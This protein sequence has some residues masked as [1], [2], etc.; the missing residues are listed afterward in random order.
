MEKIFLLSLLISHLSYASTITCPT[1]TE[2]KQHN[3]HGWVPLI[4]TSNNEPDENNVEEFL[5][6]LDSFYLAEWRPDDSYSANCYYHS[7]NELYEELYLGNHAGGINQ[8]GHW[9][10]HHS[11]EIA[12]CESES[13][14]TCRFNIKE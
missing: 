8:N 9:R 10:W 14:E 13:P 3:F 4:I 5:S 12:Y 7:N 6:N 11:H 1:I 2:L